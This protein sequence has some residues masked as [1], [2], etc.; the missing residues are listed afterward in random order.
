M[1]FENSKDA[2][3]N[4]EQFEAELQKE[5]EE[6]AEYLK[7]KMKLWKFESMLIDGMQ[8]HLERSK[9]ISVMFGEDCEFQDWISGV[10]DELCRRIAISDI[11]EKYKDA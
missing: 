7:H 4:Q 6:H 9:T 2:L 1:S 3:D 8:S 5:T 10:R 11:K